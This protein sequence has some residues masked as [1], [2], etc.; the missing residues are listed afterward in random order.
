M[1]LFQYNIVPMLYI[2]TAFRIL[3]CIYANDSKLYVQ[4]SSKSK[5]KKKKTQF[6]FTAT[7]KKPDPDATDSEDFRVSSC[8]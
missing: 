4:N 2:P 6:E 7:T 8:I 5:K 3:A 1:G